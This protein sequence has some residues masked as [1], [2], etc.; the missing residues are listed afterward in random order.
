MS[1]C[2]S[3]KK[4]GPP[5]EAQEEELTSEQ[6]RESVREHYKAIAVKSNAPDGSDGGSCCGTTTAGANSCYAPS[7]DPTYA[8]KLGYSKE[9]LEVGGDG[10]N[11]GL[12]CGNPVVFARLSPGQVVVDLGSGA[13]FDAFIASRKVGPTGRVIG[14]DMTPEMISKA[15]A[16]AKKNQSTNVEFRLGEI[17]HLPI[18]DCSVDVIISN[19]VFNLVP[20][21]CKEQVLR[22][23]MRVLKPGGRLCIS[24]VVTSVPLPPV[25]KEELANYAG[26]LNGATLLAKLETY[27]ANVGYENVKITPKDESKE[28]IKEWA[29]N[30]SVTDVIVSALIEATKPM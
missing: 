28:F 6:L 5:K 19:C 18:A 26:C 1:C 17:E 23:S 8:A 14:V 21:Q 13:G 10:A 4:C 12:G 22:D 20:E 16:N 11:L 15:R 25:V 27:L 2:S 30:H 9:D 3:E 24:D 29:P 7:S